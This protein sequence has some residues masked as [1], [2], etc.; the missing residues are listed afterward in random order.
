MGR[1]PELGGGQGQAL[2][3]GRC[4]WFGAD[5]L[6]PQKFHWGGE[7]ALQRRPSGGVASCCCVFPLRVQLAAR[8][9]RRW[10]ARLGAVI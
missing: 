7:L 6:W 3:E 2:E 10:K 5:D 1:M 8:H 9:M 4:H